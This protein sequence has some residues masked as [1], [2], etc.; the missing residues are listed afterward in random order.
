MKPLLKFHTESFS[1]QLYSG[2][3]EEKEMLSELENDEKVKEFLQDFKNYISETQEEI[4]MGIEPSRYTTI[5][6]HQMEPIGLI[7]FYDLAPELVYSCGIRPSK[8]GNQFSSRIQKE[9][10]DYVFQN[11]IEVERIIGYIDSNNTNSLNSLQK[12]TYDKI[13][14]NVDEKQGKV[15]YKVLNNNPYLTNNYNISESKIGKR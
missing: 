9:V 1:F 15:F 6:Y 7:T 2:M 11:L 5:V 12:L 3:E 13:E 4:K 14:T 10:F 8:R